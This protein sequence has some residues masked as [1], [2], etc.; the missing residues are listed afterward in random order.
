M[1]SVGKP[2]RALIRA[3]AVAAITVLCAT[4]CDRASAPDPV[5]SID[6]QNGLAEKAAE[7]GASVKWID[8]PKPLAAHV[9]ATAR[10]SVTFSSSDAVTA[11]L[12]TTEVIDGKATWEI[13]QVTLTK[14]Q[15]AKRVAGVSGAKNVECDAGIDG[16]PGSWVACR[17]NENNVGLNQSVEVAEVKG[18][19]VKLKVTPFMPEQQVVTKVA[20]KIAALYGRRPDR[21]KCDG[22]LPGIPGKTIDCVATID[23][24]ADN[25]TVTV[26][27]VSGG[28]IDFDVTPKATGASVSNLYKCPGCPG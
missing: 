12:T 28:N 13:T 26:T 19:Q 4:G 17:S 24:N 10:C 18:L 20:D 16:R 23:S 11:L 2:G 3:A 7:S 22:D 1:Q 6:L 21:T 15:V 27:G 14:D 9:G 25:W 5:S 8:C